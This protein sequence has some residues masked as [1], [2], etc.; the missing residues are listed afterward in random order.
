[1]LDPAAGGTNDMPF[2]YKKLLAYTVLA[3]TWPLG[4]YTL[5]TILPVLSI[6]STA[7]RP[8]ENPPNE[9]YGDAAMC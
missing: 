6:E 8:A 5:D 9:L 2:A 3:V 7:G 4:E 1:V